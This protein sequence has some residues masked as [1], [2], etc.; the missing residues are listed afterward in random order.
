M[1]KMEKLKML[2]AEYNRTK[3]AQGVSWWRAKQMFIMDS[4]V[5]KSRRQGAG[6]GHGPI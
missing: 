5:D 1:K 6:G 3:V 2:H 4:G